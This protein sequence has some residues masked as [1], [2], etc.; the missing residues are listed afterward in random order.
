MRILFLRFGSIGN[1]LASIPAVRAVRRE[2][3]DA[4]LALLCN[5]STYDLWKDC[6]CLDKVIV[7]DQ[8]G[9]NKPGPGYLKMIFELRKNRFTHSIHFRRFIRSELIGFLAG[10]QTRIGF[11]P[12]GFSLLTARIPYLEDEHI[13]EQDLRLV[14]ELGLEAKDKSLEYWTPAPTER[15]RKLLAQLRQAKAVV[16]LHPFA[17][18]QAENRWQKFPELAERLKKELGA[19]VVLIGAGREKEIYEKEWNQ[20]R[21]SFPA[22]FDL[23]IPELASLI[24]SAGLFIGTDSGPMHLAAAV[25]TPAIAIYG[26]RKDLDTHLK[27]WQPAVPQFKAI[28]PVNNRAEIGVEE[29]FD[30][31]IE[32]LGG[33]K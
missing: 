20:S 2:K 11:D 5:P 7:Y 22:A 1:A 25:G 21:G 31:A 12:G 32:F 10:A 28:I 8:R 15:V 24:K 9:K 18:T 17:R 4:F 19:G 13:I 3:P 23:T 6:P 27:K 16:V 33:R 29:V 30:R 14:R 26:P